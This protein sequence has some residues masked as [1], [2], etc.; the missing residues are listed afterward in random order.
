ME[1]FGK[2]KSCSVC[3]CLEIC[4]CGLECNPERRYHL[5]SDTSLYNPDTHTH[6]NGHA[7]PHTRTQKTD[8]TLDQFTAQRILQIVFAEKCNWQRSTVQLSIF[9][10]PLFFIALSGYFPGWLL[11]V[12]TEREERDRE[13]ERE[14]QREIMNSHPHPVSLPNCP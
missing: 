3:V 8:I 7:H 13:R 14:I 10:L 5:L 11:Q 6:T 2:G 12:E 1:G 4:S 9:P